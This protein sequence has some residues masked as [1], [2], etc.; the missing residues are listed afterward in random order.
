[1]TP[2]ARAHSAIEVLDTILSGTPTEQALTRWARNNRFAGSKDRAAIRDL[3]FDGIRCRRSYAVLGGAE[4]GRGLILGGM[5]ARGLNADDHFDDSTYGPPSLSEQER[6][7]TTTISDLDKTEQVDLQD[8]VWTTFQQDLGDKAFETAT[9]LRSRADVFLRVNLRKSDLQSAIKQL[10]VDG[11][12]AEPH[13]LS[14]TA[15]RV[16]SNPRRVA[17]SS[18]YKDGQVE[19]Q[20]AASQAVCDF[21]NLP[22]GGDILDY[23]AGGGGKSLAMA[24]R[25]DAKIHAHDAN[26]GRMKDIP[27][28]ANRAGVRIQCLDKTPNTKSY[29]LVVCD[30]PCSGSGSWRRSLDGKWSITP[31]TLDALLKT[32]AEILRNAAAL[33]TKGGELAYATCSVLAAENRDQVQ[34]FLDACPDWVLIKDRQFLPQDGGDGFYIARLTRQ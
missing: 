32:Q 7:L 19:L 18:A 1:M 14:P 13:P 26:V 3:V 27:Q 15:L 16:T 10:K 20:D 4:T 8:W 22:T 31:E 11:I 12:E 23:C 6:A 21:I 25:T 5:R 9:A 2:A 17:Q 29:E 34:T 28:R 24:A 30:V 33:V